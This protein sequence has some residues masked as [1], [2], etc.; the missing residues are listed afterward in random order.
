MNYRKGNHTW[1]VAETSSRIF[2]KSEFQQ[3]KKTIVDDF[4]TTS[5]SD[6]TR[7]SSNRSNIVKTGYQYD[8]GTK[9]SISLDLQTGQTRFT[10]GGDMEYDELRKQSD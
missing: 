10:R 6:G 3:K 2:G 4:V 5:E 9:H 8:D 7:F 1:Y